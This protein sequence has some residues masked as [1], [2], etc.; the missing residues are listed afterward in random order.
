[1]F[2]LSRFV[3]FFFGPIPVGLYF[4]FFAVETTHVLDWPPS[5]PGVAESGFLGAG[6]VKR[7]S[8]VSAINE[9]WPSPPSDPE[10]E[11]AGPSSLDTLPCLGRA[12]DTLPGLRALP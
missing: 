2:I 5:P 4:C 12:R 3:F 7:R 1:M 9:A 10:D 8:A 11:P 6:A